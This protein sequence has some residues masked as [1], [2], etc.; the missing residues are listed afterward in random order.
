MLKNLRDH[1]R[2]YGAVA[3]AVLLALSV[4]YHKLSREVR[5]WNL[6]NES[7]LH[8]SPRSIQRLGV[9]KVTSGNPR[10]EAGNALVPDVPSPYI[11][12]ET[13]V[14][15]TSKVQGKTV[16]DLVSIEYNKWGFTF[17]PGLQFAVFPKGV[18]LDAK[19]FYV[20]RA[21]LGVG[22]PYLIDYGVPG[23]DLWVSYRLDKFKYTKNTEVVTGLMV[24][25]YNIGF[26]GLRINF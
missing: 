16:D 4:A 11:P 7:V 6:I 24:L 22:I 13:E 8:L 18:G 12:P 1:W 10:E 5:R 15:I 21:G 17:R 3:M 25:P 2:L 23:L 20:S 9:K 26:A 19:L 14:T